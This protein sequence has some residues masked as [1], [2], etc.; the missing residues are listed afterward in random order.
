VV[1]PEDKTNINLLVDLLTAIV[2]PVDIARI[3]MPA[4]TITSE[5]ALAMQRS[6][7]GEEHR[8]RN[9]HQRFESPLMR[10][11]KRGAFLKRNERSAGRFHVVFHHSQQCACLLGVVDAKSPDSLGKEAIERLSGHVQVEAPLNRT[12]YGVYCLPICSVFLPGAIGREI[13]VRYAGREQFKGAEVLHFQ[14]DFY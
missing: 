6:S 4:Y 1:L 8:F 14:I 9:Q 2:M 7:D 3:G 10:A 13:R 12:P 5:L 11:S